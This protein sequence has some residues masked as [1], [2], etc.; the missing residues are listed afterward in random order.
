M[1]LGLGVLLGSEESRIFIRSEYSFFFQLYDFEPVQI[2][3]DRLDSRICEWD[4]IQI[5]VLRGVH[6]YHARDVSRPQR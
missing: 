6:E 5:A 2:S 3:V 4:E 1:I